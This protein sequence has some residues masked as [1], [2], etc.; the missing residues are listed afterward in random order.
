MSHKVVFLDRDGVLNALVERNSR[1]V[2]P[3]LFKDFLLLDGVKDAIHLLLQQNYKVIV[4][5]NQPDISRGLMLQ[6]ELDQMTKAL[7]DLGINQ[8]LICPHSDEDACQCR[9][10]KPGLLT[11]YLDSLDSEPKAIWMI[12]DCEVDMRAGDAVGAK[13]IYISKNRQEGT[14]FATQPNLRLAVQGI[15]GEL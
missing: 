4:V 14:A 5:T 15:T 2:S 11:R 10:P 3:R 13:T 9:K 1:M 8:V 6:S 7:L 12:G